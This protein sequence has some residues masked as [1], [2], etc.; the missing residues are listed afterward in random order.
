M[1]AITLQTDTYYA[2]FFALALIY[3][4]KMINNEIQYSIQLQVIVL[5]F[6][7][8]CA[9]LFRKEGIWILGATSIV[10]IINS[11]FK[12]KIFFIGFF[13]K[14]LQQESHAKWNQKH[15]EHDQHQC[16][17]LST[18]FCSRKRMKNCHR[19]HN[20]CYQCF[21]VIDTILI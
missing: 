16:S 3:M 15:Y 12:R 1:Y 17:N 7:M 21:H 6:F 9:S 18:V 13:H 4:L 2:C 11:K 5:A 8:I 19:K 20:V 10:L 14:S